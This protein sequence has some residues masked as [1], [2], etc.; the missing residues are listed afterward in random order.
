M[1]APSGFVNHNFL[2]A[3]SPDQSYYPLSVHNSPV[4]AFISHSSPGFDLS[5][6]VA[7]G[8]SVLI[9][10]PDPQSAPQLH[11]STRVPHFDIETMRNINYQDNELLFGNIHNTVPTGGAF[12]LS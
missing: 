5:H 4:P 11:S 10:E 7:G 2:K 1:F 3:P 8:E 9:M 12:T 6:Q